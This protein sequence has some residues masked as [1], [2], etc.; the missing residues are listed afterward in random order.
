[1]DILNPEL[2]G[3]TAHGPNCSCWHLVGPNKFEQGLIR[4]QN[5]LEDGQVEIEMLFCGHCESDTTLV[6]LGRHPSQKE[7]TDLIL[8]G[9]E[10]VGRIVRLGSGVSNLRVGQIVAVEPGISCGNCLECHRGRYNL[11]R[12]VKY[13]ATPGPGWSYGCY[14][15]TIR[16]PAELCF[17]VPES[18][19]PMLAALTESMAAG[20]QSIDYVSK[21]DGFDADSETLVLTGAGQMAMNILLQARRRWQDLNIVVMARKSEDR[22]LAL[23]FGAT[24]VVALSELEWNAAANLE[25]LLTAAECDDPQLCQVRQKAEAYRVAQAHN[26]EVHRQNIE[27]FKLVREIAREEVACVLE[28]TGQPHILSAAL[29]ARTIRGDGSYGLVSCLYDF[30]LNV[31]NLR[32]DGARVW[33]LRRSRNQFPAVLKKLALDSDYY[34]KLIG[35][36]IDF[37]N[38][39]DLYQGNRGTKTG[40]GP[41]VMIK[42]NT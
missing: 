18:L 31:A 2:S 35:H 27:A 39:P 8:P 22:E 14:S 21:T 5:K 29:D 42:Y 15:H 10:P 9:H 34:N 17:P 37:N 32:R 19:D 7:A 26:A 4:H 20:R 6:K 11:C 30:S 12:K 23:K 38:V 1:M 36:V 40:P 28:C 16:W 3:V 24:H 13:M 33:N 41:K 25:H